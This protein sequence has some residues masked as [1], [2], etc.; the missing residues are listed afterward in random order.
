MLLKVYPRN[1]KN[2][3]MVFESLVKVKLCSF[4]K[5]SASLCHGVYEPVVQ[6]P[7]L[8]LCVK[9][10]LCVFHNSERRSGLLGKSCHCVGRGELVLFA[11]PFL[12]EL[13]KKRSENFRSEVWCR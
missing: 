11:A 10:V 7:H 6:E 4:A 8:L 3:Q 12:K 9:P 1:L 5:T 13:N 2:S